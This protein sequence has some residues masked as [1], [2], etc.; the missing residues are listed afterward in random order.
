[1]KGKRLDIFG[2]D[3]AGRYAHGTH[4]RY[5]LGPCR[6]FP[7]KL[8]NAE[9]ETAR[10]SKDD[11][12]WHCRII[13]A[14]GRLKGQYYVINRDTKE[15]VLRSFDREEAWAEAARLNKRDVKPRQPRPSQL[16]S[17]GKIRKHARWLQTQGIGLK[18]L[19]KESRVAYSSLERML[20]QGQHDRPIK[21]TRRSTLE[22]ILAVKPTAIANGARVEAGP[23]VELLSRLIKRGYRKFW[24]AKQLGAKSKAGRPPLQITGKN[25]FVSVRNARKVFALYLRLQENDWRLLKVAPVFII[26]KAEPSHR[27]SGR[28]LAA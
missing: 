15:I 17:V 27:R 22:R 5:A 13:N 6:R 1:M 12:L 18:R 2:T 8:A 26:P 21:R 3:K 28:Q 23:T 25:G 9:Y 11:R 16:V 10:Y 19:A 7:C 4:A 24:I 14:R 20:G